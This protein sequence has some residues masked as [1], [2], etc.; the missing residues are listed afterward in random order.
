MSKAPRKHSRDTDDP[1]DHARASAS[2]RLRAGT[3][4][5]RKSG[6]KKAA[7]RSDPADQM[8]E[9]FIDRELMG[10][11]HT[12]GQ[13][14]S[15]LSSLA[16]RIA[17]PHARILFA[18]IHQTVP[19]QEAAVLWKSIL[20]H[21]T[22]LEAELGRGVRLQVAALDFFSGTGERGGQGFDE[23][24]VQL[25]TQQ[26]LERLVH[27][28]LTDGLTGAISHTYFHQLLQEEYY[29]SQRYRRPLSLVMIDVDDFKLVNDRFGHQTGDRVLV[30]IADVLRENMRKSD[31]LARYGGEE[32]AVILPEVRKT[33]ACKLAEKLRR[34][35]AA[36]VPPRAG[37]TTPL[38]VSMGVATLTAKASSTTDLIRNA[39]MA[40]YQAKEGGKDRVV[41]WGALRTGRAPNALI[42]SAKRDSTT[43][44]RKTLRAAGMR[45]R[46]AA[47]AIAA[48]EAVAARPP[49][50]IVA[51]NNLPKGDLLRFC[52][53]VP[54]NPLNHAVK[55]IV[56]VGGQEAE[57][58]DSLRGAGVDRLVAS[59]QEERALLR[60]V[61]A[62]IKTA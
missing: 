58:R 29:R 19:E 38:T 41:H 44:L 57:L 1:G 24:R 34:E 28:A 48:L 3:P 12:R 14:E 11:V 46:A 61:S 25:I 50:L 10:D 20:R 16:E 27:S 30:V 22:R 31:R 42:L 26:S 51:E 33:G 23:H 56:V 47:S 5:S 49:D 37:I 18:L 15:I 8:L 9:A 59:S 55:L 6:R 21:K 45:V 40:L 4:A 35:L 39:D 17:E 2:A 43:L 60:A 32:F 62:L 36:C 7:Q 52:Q 53:L 54:T 13:I